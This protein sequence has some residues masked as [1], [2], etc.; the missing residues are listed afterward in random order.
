MERLRKWITTYLREVRREWRHVNWPTRKEAIYL[1]AVV[2]VISL[3]LAGMM[4]L[5]DFLFSSALSKIV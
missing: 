4:G 3:V 5:F 1:T 2:I